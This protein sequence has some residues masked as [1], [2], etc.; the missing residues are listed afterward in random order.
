MRAVD[1]A[2]LVASRFPATNVF[3]SQT[4]PEVNECMTVFRY[5]GESNLDLVGYDDYAFQVAAKSVSYDASESLADE[6]YRAL[7]SATRVEINEWHVCHVIANSPPLPG[8]QDEN[9]RWVVTVNFRV[10]AYKREAQDGA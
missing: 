9:G 5:G 1:F 3:H 4:P 2:D 8:W 7:H 10:K 6:V